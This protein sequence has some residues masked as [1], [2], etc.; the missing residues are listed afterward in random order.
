MVDEGMRDERWS[1]PTSATRGTIAGTAKGPMNIG[2]ARRYGSRYGS[3]NA[4]IPCK[5]WFGTA[6]T[7]EMPAGGAAGREKRD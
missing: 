2:L 5:H 7:A 6:G 1:K 4:G 3:Q